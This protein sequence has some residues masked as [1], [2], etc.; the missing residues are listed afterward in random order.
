MRGYARA[1]GSLR[2]RADGIATGGVELMYESAVV[3]V[4]DFDARCRVTMGK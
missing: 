3:A 2:G 1:H 4:R